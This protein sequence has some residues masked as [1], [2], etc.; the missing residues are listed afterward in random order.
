MEHL[1]HIDLYLHQISELSSDVETLFNINFKLLNEALN[2]WQKFKEIP[3]ISFIH[4]SQSHHF[5][6]LAPKEIRISR[7]DSLVGQSGIRFN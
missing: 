3:F 2:R 1:L 5:R 7:C 6:P 4:C